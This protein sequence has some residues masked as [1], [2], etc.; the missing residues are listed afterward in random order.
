MATDQWN[1]L[2]PDAKRIATVLAND[3]FGQ[4]LLALRTRAQLGVVVL[5]A[6]LA[7][8][9]LAG[10]L[11]RQDFT[12]SFPANAVALTVAL[13]FILYFVQ[14]RRMPELDY[15]VLVCCAM[16]VGAIWGRGFIPTLLIGP[17]IALIY[18][19]L[20]PKV[21][22]L[23]CSGFIVASLTAFH[24]GGH[25][26][27]G[28]VMQRLV[29]GQLV[30]L[31]AVHLVM[32][33]CL[34]LVFDLLQN[35][36]A[37]KQATD[38]KSR[39]LSAVS[40]ELRTPLNGIQGMVYGLRQTPLSRTQSELVGDLEISSQH[41][42]SLVSDV[43]DFARLEANQ[44]AIANQP[45]VVKSVL[46]SV[47]A[48]IKPAALAKGLQYLSTMDESC[49]V[50]WVADQRRLIQSLVNL[51][52]NAVKF[53]KQGSVS[54]HVRLVHLQG[55]QTALRFTVQDTGIGIS[56]QA[57]DKLFKPFTQA[58]DE[59][60]V[61][62]GG[63]G[64]GLAL[65]RELVERMGG[66]IDYESSPGAGSTFWIDLAEPARAPTLESLNDTPGHGPEA[67][68]KYLPAGLVG[69]VVDDAPIN[70]KVAAI[71][72]NKL[73]VK[74]AMAVDG[75]QGLMA[76]QERGA[77]FDFLLMDVHMPAMT[78]LEATRA[79]RA[80]DRNFDVPII[81]LTGAALESEVQEAMA[82]GMDVVLFKP[83]DPTSLLRALEELSARIL[84]RRNALQARNAQPIQTSQGGQA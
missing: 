55:G 43:L 63:T 42:N 75:L 34:K 2:W 51:M 27:E 84:A 66:H 18:C 74:V 19:V 41:L 14:T 49:P 5:I 69:L 62:Y 60:F 58:S 37:L 61:H 45:F 53:T 24:I 73:G 28:A 12:L 8:S 16:V 47:N 26:V 33:F 32:T 22:L 65:C 44:L 15:F 30:V 50:L 82:S 4:R 80:L 38:A 21:A 71:F 20:Y 6:I 76:V 23:I 59:T 11:L 81:G 56:A 40:H 77:E 35:R 29:M 46:D 67:T 83:L 78:G 17:V 72:L 57:R 31:L 1:W 68:R 79:I 36:H 10:D 3:E 64:L 48:M 7:F 54:L 39:F 52:N 9:N 13:G 70:R 25:A